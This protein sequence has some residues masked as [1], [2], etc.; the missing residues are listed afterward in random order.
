[1]KGLMLEGLYEDQERR[2]GNAH[3][4]ILSFGDHAASRH[5]Q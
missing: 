4:L 1:M 5:C 2:H 3:R